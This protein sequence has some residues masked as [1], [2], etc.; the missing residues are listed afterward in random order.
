MSDDIVFIDGLIFK[1]PKDGTPDFVKAKLSI[2]REELI[3]FLQG[4]EGEWINA[5]LKESRAGK[6]YCAI[7]SWKPDE[8]RQ[9]AEQAPQDDGD[10]I[11][12]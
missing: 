8:N 1:K 2:K 9:Q 4:Q 11:P 5:D 7:D 12:F 3:A 6:L 10:S